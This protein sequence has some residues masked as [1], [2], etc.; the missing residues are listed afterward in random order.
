MI[1]VPEYLKPYADDVR[2]RKDGVTFSLRCPCGC[3][4]FLLLKNGP[5]KDEK[6]RLREYNDRLAGIGRHTLYEGTDRNGKS[7]SYIR[8]LGIFKKHIDAGEEPL[9][10]RIKAV[11]AECA[12]CRRQIDIFDSR[13]HGFDSKFATE[14]EQRYDLH[15]PQAKDDPCKV[16][17]KV[18]ENE[19]D[20]PLHFSRIT[21]WKENNGKKKR[22][23][24]QQT[25]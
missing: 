6:K 11:K 17:L 9:S 18:E 3:D 10:Q 13:K 7:Y 8:I 16:S 14:E 19:K 2:I 20:D 5:S 4:S 21:V 23:F 15:F 1:A 22:F 24:G 25:A 12:S